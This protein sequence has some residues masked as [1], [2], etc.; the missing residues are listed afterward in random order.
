MTKPKLAPVPLPK[1]PPRFRFR[2]TDAE[3]S[4]VRMATL[5][6]GTNG[7]YYPPELLKRLLEQ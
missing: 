5:R 6:E 1:K 2:L 7:I 3:R 4:R